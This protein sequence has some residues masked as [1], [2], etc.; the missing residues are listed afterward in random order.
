M[1]HFRELILLVLSVRYWL[2]T[3]YNYFTQTVRFPDQSDHTL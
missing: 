1:R 3:D 2:V